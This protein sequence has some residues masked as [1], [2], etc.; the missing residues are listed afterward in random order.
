LTFLFQMVFP[1][2]PSSATVWP[3]ELEKLQS[4]KPPSA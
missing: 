1:V 3:E 4:T 2:A